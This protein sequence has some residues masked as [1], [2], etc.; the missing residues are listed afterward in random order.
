MRF[1]IAAH[2]RTAS[3][4]AIRSILEHPQAAGV[5]EPFNQQPKSRA[6]VPL[7][8]NRKWI[9]HED[10]VAFAKSYLFRAPANSGVTAQGFKI[11][12]QHCARTEL[13]KTLWS[14][15]QS[16]NGIRVILMRRQNLAKAYISHCRALKAD[17]W[18]I[19]SNSLT[20]EGYN[21]PFNV[22]I[23]DCRRFIANQLESIAALQSIFADHPKVEI[24]YEEI[25]GDYDASIARIW[26]FLELSPILLD[27]P[28]RKVS[29]KPLP[30]VVLNYDELKAALAESPAREHGWL[31]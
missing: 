27:Q 7:W 15:L 12:R 31:D 17:A 16:E 24:S 10:P 1:V 18:N 3:T 29:R 4:L 11:F 19:S 30:D 8:G 23:E 5:Y 2:P 14:Y 26:A 21:T 22:D 20:P 6:N 28:V 25:T 9:D 13:Q